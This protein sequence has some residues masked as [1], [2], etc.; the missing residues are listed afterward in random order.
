M[1]VSI[2]TTSVSILF[3][4]VSAQDVATLPVFRV[5]PADF[6]TSK[7]ETLMKNVFRNKRYSTSFN[8]TVYTVKTNNGA[9]VHL[10]LLS[11]GTW[12]MDETKLWNISKPCNITIPE[13]PARL[14]ESYAQKH[15]LFPV[16]GPPF[17]IEHTGISSTQLTNE[18][19]TKKEHVFE[20]DHFFLDT[21]AHYE[22]KVK[23]PSHPDPIP[24]T[25][26]GGKFQITLGDRGSLI[27]YHGVWRDVI[28]EGVEYNIITKEKSD[29]AFLNATKTLEIL[30]F[31][32]TLAYYSAPFGRLQNFLFPVYVYNATAKFENETVSLRRTLF[33][34]T[35][36]GI[37]RFIGCSEGRP[38]NTTRPANGNG[39]STTPSKRELHRRG[40]D[41]SRWS[42]GTE[43]LGKD[44]N[45]HLTQQ[46]ANSFADY[47]RADGHTPWQTGFMFGDHLVWESDFDAYDDVWVD[48]VD[49]VFYTGHANLN[50]WVAN[51]PAST[52]VDHSIVG[53][54]P[55]N[56]GDK[57]GAKDLEWLVIAACGPHQDDR[58]VAG[59]GSG[60]AF[61]RWRGVF[62]G[63]HI[64]LAYA[65]ETYDT[66]DEGWK[67]VHY[68]QGGSSLIQ[69]WFRQA[70]ESQP[71]GIWVT[72]MWAETPGNNAGND[73]LPGYGY[74]ANDPVAGNQQS[75]WLMWTKT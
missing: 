10:D 48:N 6:S 42:F 23:L 45:L 41:D 47:L 60:N 46:E 43:W 63:M 20:Y 22:V 56:P 70:K 57:W 51:A 3:A 72:A 54:F 13:N 4:A 1:H 62:D 38:V 68:A 71:G 27:G 55:E 12:L 73:H 30:E 21:T 64:M 52:F 11:G 59:E 58:I 39:N 5:K 8:D 65:T 17:T 67:L 29:E 31:N 32:S 33:P 19:P 9:Y 25:G 15:E 50:G 2:F 7:A 16:V 61:D 69:A 74:I 75:R 53:A 35:D 26:G 18:K 44:W 36:F 14:S 24:I 28:N 40:N 66:A 49:F 37:E 34:A